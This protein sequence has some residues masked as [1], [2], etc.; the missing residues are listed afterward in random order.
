[1]KTVKAGIEGIAP[2]LFNRFTEK[3][4]QNL[5][6]GSQG[7]PA[8]KQGR[9]DEAYEKV[10]RNG[11]PEI[12]VPTLHIKKCILEGC[13]MA[14]IKLGR[15]SAVAYIRAVVFPQSDFMPLHKPSGEVYTK[16][17]GI[18]E[19]VGNIPPGPK[20]KKAIIRRPYCSPGWKGEF[21]LDIFDERVSPDMVKASLE[22][23]G[24]LCGL[25]DHRPEYG[26]FKV[27]SFEET[28]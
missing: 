1:M 21:V 11:G 8:T 7:K 13:R 22:E 26:R 6:K 25:C 5:E 15:S 27:V 14:K 28:K 12:G 19:C 17:D 18:H 10:Y 20:G 23:A 3:A 4:Q 16:P 9:I 24:V 2:I